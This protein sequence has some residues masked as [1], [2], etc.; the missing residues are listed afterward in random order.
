MGKWISVKERLPEAEGRYLCTVRGFFA[1]E[2]MAYFPKSQTWASSLIVDP[3]VTHW[4][5]LPAPPE[6]NHD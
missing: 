5:P 6:A 3:P 4:Q 1:A 2:V